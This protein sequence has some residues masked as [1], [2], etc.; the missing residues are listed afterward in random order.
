VKVLSKWKS[1]YS[2]ANAVSGFLAGSTP[3]SAA[4]GYALAR[5]TSRAGGRLAMAC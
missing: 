2:G 5:F 4:A 3:P 1:G